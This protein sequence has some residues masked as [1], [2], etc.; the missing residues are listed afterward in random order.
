MEES[1]L[2]S[3]QPPFNLGVQSL[4]TLKRPL[5]CVEISFICPTLPLHTLIDWG[6]VL[7]FSHQGAHDLHKLYHLI[8]KM[9]QRNRH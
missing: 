5:D 3:S 2:R 1:S 6:V 8:F 4:Q 9:P 7:L